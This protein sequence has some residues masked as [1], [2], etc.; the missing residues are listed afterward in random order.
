M[1]RVILTTAIIVLTLMSCTPEEQVKEIESTETTETN[2]E[3]PIEDD[4]EPTPEPVAF[5]GEWVLWGNF[6]PHCTCFQWLPELSEEPIL[7]IDEDGTLT[8]EN[9]TYSY[10]VDGGY[11]GDD[12]SVDRIIVDDLSTLE[13]RKAGGDCYNEMIPSD[14]YITIPSGSV[15]NML[16]GVYSSGYFVLIRI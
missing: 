8:L 10:S 3:E 5:A 2:T 12:C 1:K 15:D 7:I 16:D 4:E 13:H 14:R 6:A 11:T 9:T